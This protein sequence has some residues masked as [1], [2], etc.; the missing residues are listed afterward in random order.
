MLLPGESSISSKELPNLEDYCKWDWDV[1]TYPYKSTN[2]K[3]DSD[4]VTYPHFVKE[5]GIIRQVDQVFKYDEVFINETIQ[6]VD[7]LDFYYIISLLFIVKQGSTHSTHVGFFSF[8]RM[9]GNNFFVNNQKS[10][11]YNGM[12]SIFFGQ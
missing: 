12:N 7:N 10:V 8:C 5:N 2:V 9:T 4:T 1:Q 11:V 6:A 3:N